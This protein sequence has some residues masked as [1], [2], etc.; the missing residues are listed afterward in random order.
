VDVEK[1]LNPERNYD[2][3]TRA[4]DRRK[5]DEAICF[6]TPVIDQGKAKADAA[7]YWKAYALAKLGRTAEATASLDALSQKYPQSRWLTDAKV[8]KAEV[9]RAAGK[10]LSPEEQ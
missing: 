3:G 7:L 8:L 9:Q 6:F 10:P 1:S 4:L 2:R 5:W